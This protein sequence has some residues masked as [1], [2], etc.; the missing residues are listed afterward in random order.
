LAAESGTDAAD[1][2]DGPL[3]GADAIGDGLGTD[4]K[5]AGEFPGGVKF[6]DG[7]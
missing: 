6:A 1:A 5:D 3:V 4:G 2:L 7:L